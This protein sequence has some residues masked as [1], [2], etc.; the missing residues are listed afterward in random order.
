MCQFSQQIIHERQAVY[1]T[2]PED[3][4]LLLL[5]IYLIAFIYDIRGEKIFFIIPVVAY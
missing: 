5:K 2:T 1:S 4:I 3:S